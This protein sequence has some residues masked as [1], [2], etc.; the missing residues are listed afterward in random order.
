MFVMVTFA[1][2]SIST[3][4]LKSPSRSGRAQVSIHSPVM[5]LMIGSSMISIVSFVSLI[6]TLI[7]CVM[8]V[9]LISSVIFSVILVV[10]FRVKLPIT[11]ILP[12]FDLFSTDSVVTIICFVADWIK[13][14]FS[15]IEVVI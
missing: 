2:P 7:S 1:S 15:K 4:N 13:V 12:P 8:F 5:C 9:S 10:M 3:T 6:V 11:V 14:S